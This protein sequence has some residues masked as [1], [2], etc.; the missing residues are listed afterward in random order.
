MAEDYFT[1]V[2][3]KPLPVLE[4]IFKLSSS[5]RGQIFYG[6]IRIEFSNGG[7]MNLGYVGDDASG[8][9]MFGILL[10]DGTTNRLF[11]GIQ[12]DGF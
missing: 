6:D 7:F 3:N 8:N 9:P 2:E 5:D 1:D 11:A 4:D 10:N 12:Q